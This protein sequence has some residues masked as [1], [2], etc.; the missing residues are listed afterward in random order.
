M[1]TEFVT[2]LPHLIQYTI[3]AM[4]IHV[5]YVLS[6]YLEFFGVEY[7]CSSQWG[8]PLLLARPKWCLQKA[9]PNNGSA[10]QTS[11]KFSLG[12]PWTVVFTGYMQ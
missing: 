4:G 6:I 1:H 12:N 7:T 11:G 10:V 9:I 5:W 8:P 3:H 2:K